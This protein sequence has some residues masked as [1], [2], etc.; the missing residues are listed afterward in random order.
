M[1]SASQAYLYVVR[2]GQSMNCPVQSCTHV[3]LALTLI[4]TLK[5]PGKPRHPQFVHIHALRVAYCI[6]TQYNKPAIPVTKVCASSYKKYP[7]VF[8]MEMT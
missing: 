8:R 7:H 5:L 3:S 4:L 2:Y 6:H 1:L